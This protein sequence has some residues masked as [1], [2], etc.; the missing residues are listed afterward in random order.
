MRKYSLLLVLIPTTVL[1]QGTDARMY[2]AFFP[3]DPSHFPKQDAIAIWDNL[4]P[5][6]SGDILAGS[7]DFETGAVSGTCVYCP[8]GWSCTCTGTSAMTQEAVKIY[9]NSSSVK[10]SVDAINSIIAVARGSISMEAG[11]SYQISWKMR[12]EVG[13]EDAKYSIRSIIGDYYAPTT[14]TWG[15]VVE[16]GILNMAVSWTQYTTYVTCGAIPRSV[17]FTVTRLNASQVFYIDDVQVIK[18]R[19]TSQVSAPGSYT[20]APAVTSDPVYAGARS[21]QVIAGQRTKRGLYFDGVNDALVMT[22]DDNKFD[23]TQTGHFSVCSEGKGETGTAANAIIIAKDGVGQRSWF[24]YWTG[25]Q[26]AAYISKDGG[27]V[28]ISTAAKPIAIT[29]PFAG[30]FSYTRI[31][32]GGSSLQLCANH[33]STCANNVTSVAPI[34]NGT[35]PIGIAD[36]YTLG[37]Q[38]F[39][40]AVNR[41]GI[42]NMPLSAA[43]ISRWVSP[44]FAKSIETTGMYV[45]TCTQAASHAIC[46][47]SKCVD[48]T[49]NRCVPDSQ[50]QPIF[51]Q[52]T[53]A[54]SYNSVETVVGGDDAPTFTGYSSY[55]DPAATLTAYRADTMHGNISMRV[56][57]PSLTYNEIYGPCETA[58]VGNVIQGWVAMKKLVD[59]PAE[60]YVQLWSYTD[61]A[62]T[63]GTSYASLWGGDATSVWD[64]Y[65]G[66][67]STAGK[68]SYRVV[69]SVIQNNDTPT[70]LLIDTWS[71]VASPVRTPWVHAAGAADVV[72]NS[73]DYRVHNPLADV[74][75]NGRYAYQDGFCAGMWVSSDWAAD[76]GVGKY[77]VAVLGTAGSSNYWHI[78]KHT[79]NSIYFSIYDNAAVALQRYLAVTSAN[80][81]VGYPK[82]V[83]ACSS[84]TGTIVA[85]HY[86]TGTSTW[87]SWSGSS[88]AGTGIFAGQTA[89]IHVG[90]NTGLP[91]DGYLGPLVIGPYK[92]SWPLYG[93]DKRPRQSP[94]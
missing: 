67:V 51:G 79:N 47:P 9:K 59:L 62:C 57:A 87:Y 80:W 46:D 29:T 92:S 1:A 85:R 78:F 4:D 28:N 34:F 86:D 24:H 27:S 21:I 43:N 45:T 77:L 38:S 11:A 26:L 76:D 68:S 8:T 3:G 12:G 90:G 2:G 22:T 89:N 31:S 33:E 88:G 15:A 53:E 54:C 49:A 18:L 19:N 52:Y 16:P 17:V 74:R 75:P 30:C 93:F 39:L 44:Y 55:I 69:V 32:D 23:A 6:W 64:W 84:N 56:K 73:R 61:A 37:D 72:V 14:D 94:Y 42:Y 36:A 41:I 58:G 10:I 35:A 13:G 5:G 20:L 83:E 65:G 70:D 50:W 25:A 81:T 40:G 48:G 71:A 66:S 7:G 63:T 60:L 91:M 82:Y